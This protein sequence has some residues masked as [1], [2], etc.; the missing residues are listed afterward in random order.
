MTLHIG[1]MEIEVVRTGTQAK[2]YAR[3]G[4]YRL[5]TAC[6]LESLEQLAANLAQEA[7][8]WR[9][10]RNTIP[11]DLYAVLGVEHDASLDEIRESYRRLARQYHP[12][13]SSGETGAAMTQ[14][15]KAYE[16][17]SD[18]NTRQTYDATLTS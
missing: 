11:T 12:D 10:E 4:I 8:A 16:T 13:M 15:N 1:T 14:I 9:R 17:L 2:F 3:A 18:D 6:E 5:E 7:M